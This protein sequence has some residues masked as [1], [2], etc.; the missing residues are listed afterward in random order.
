MSSKILEQMNNSFCKI[1]NK[2][3]IGLFCCIRYNKSKIPAIIKN[4]Y[5]KK[6]E[7]FNIIKMILNNKEETIAISDIIYKNKINNISIIK[8]KNYNNKNKHIKYIELDDKLYEEES[9]L[10]YQNESI[11]IIQKIKNYIL[12]LYG[13]IKDINKN[14]IIYTGNINS[15]YSF[16]FNLNNNKLI[17]IHKDNTKYCYNKGILFKSIIKG[18]KNYLTNI[19]KIGILIDIKKKI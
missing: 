13:I 17:G 6:E 1:K 15:N 11:Y 9:E 19:N 16:I 3:D 7:Y 5:I 14:E 8:N 2:K 18:I 4:N 12:V 10:Y